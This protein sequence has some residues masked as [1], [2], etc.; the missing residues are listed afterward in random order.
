MIGCSYDVTKLISKIPKY[1]DYE[2][3][4]DNILTKLLKLSLKEISIPKKNK[5]VKD[6]INKKS[7]FRHSSSFGKLKISDTI[8]N[9][10]SCIIAY[11][12]SDINEIYSIMKNLGVNIVPVVKNPWNK[13]L[14]G[15]IN[16]HQLEK[17]LK[18]VSIA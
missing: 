17:E 2:N 3:N 6:F 7:L 13:K 10:A 18:K 11:P 4:L 5:T 8:K 15:F 16:K 9:D 12:E 14:M 1:M